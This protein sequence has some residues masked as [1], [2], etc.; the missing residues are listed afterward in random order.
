[1]DLLHLVFS[2]GMIAATLR[3]AVSVSFV[4]L[5]TVFATRS[6]VMHMGQEGFMLIAGLAGAALSSILDSAFLGLLFSLL[7]GAIAGLIYAFFTV[8]NRGNDII[9]GVGFNFFAL[10]LTAIMIQVVWGNQGSSPNVPGIYNFMTTIKANAGSVWQQIFGTQNVLFIVLL[11][12]ALLSWV[13]LYRTPYGLRIRIAGELPMAVESAGGSVIRLRYLCLVISGVLIALAGST[14]AL[15]QVKMF[16]RDMMAGRGYV[17]LAM[18]ALGRYH[19]IGALVGSLLFGFTDALQIRLQG[20]GV[21]AQFVQMIPYLFTI[22]VIA[23]S[24]AGKAP[25]ALGKPFPE[26]D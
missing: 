17:G 8:S 4:A 20:E 13:F 6:G 12:V 23:L 21:P 2:V 18:C 24:G 5:G 19:P 10:G 7:A 9:V 15:G 1:M 22:V 3:L 14:V 16:G 11:V 25:A 26:S